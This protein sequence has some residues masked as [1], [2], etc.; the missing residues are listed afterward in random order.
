[1]RGHQDLTSEFKYKEVTAGI[2][3]HAGHDICY[4]QK[5][6]AFTR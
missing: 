6:G 2:V 4:L 1:M 5:M 3:M